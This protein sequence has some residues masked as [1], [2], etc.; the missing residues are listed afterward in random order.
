MANPGFR[1][2]IEVETLLV[3]KDT[4]NLPEGNELDVF[5]KAL[6]KKYNEMRDA[7]KNFS[8][9]ADVGRKYQGVEYQDWVL[10]DDITIRGD[11]DKYCI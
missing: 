6:A 1:L 10:T 11:E 3:R 7:Q 8:M 9:R 4:K 2:G 5:A